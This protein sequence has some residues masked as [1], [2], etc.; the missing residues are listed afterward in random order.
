LNQEAINHLNKSI[1]SNKIEINK[2]T[3]NQKRPGLHG[4]AA[5]FFKTFKKELTTML[6]KLFHKIEGNNATKLT[7]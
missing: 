2:Q 5:E 4:F 1:T 7:L 3:P 6:F